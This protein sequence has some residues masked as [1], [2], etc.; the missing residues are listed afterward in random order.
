MPHFFLIWKKK[1][2]VDR[3]HEYIPILKNSDSKKMTTFFSFDSTLHILIHGA[4]Q[5][6]KPPQRRMVRADL[7]KIH[8]SSA[9]PQ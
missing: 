1:R 8:Q 4:G 5:Q 6:A 9:I 2:A 3:K 7:N